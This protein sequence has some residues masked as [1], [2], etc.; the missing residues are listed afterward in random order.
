MPRLVPFALACLLVATT[1][2]AEWYEREE[3]I[4]GTRVAVQLWATDPDLAGMR[5]GRGHGRHAAHRRADEHLQAREPAVA[6]Q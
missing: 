3:A 6:G 4:M 5:D 2:H 1:A